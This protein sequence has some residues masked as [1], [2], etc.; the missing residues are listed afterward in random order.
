M[1]MKVIEKSKMSDFIKELLKVYEV[2]APVKDKNIVTFEK[3]SSENQVYLNFQNTKKPLKEVF[4]PQNETLFTYK[5]NGKDMQIVEPP[6]VNGERVVLVVRPCDAKSLVLMDKVFSGQYEDV[7]YLKKRNN[8]TIIGLACNHPLSTCFCTS[9][10]GSP[11]GKEGM[12][13]LLHDLNDKYLLESVTQKGEELIKKFP[14]LKE[15]EQA[16]VEKAKRLSEDAEKSIKCKISVKN[17][18]EELGKKF[19]DPMW[20]QFYQKCLGC[21]ICAFLCPTCTCFDVVDEGTEEGK[22]VRIWDCCQFGCFTLHGSG[23][24]PRPS[25]KERTRQRI[26]HKF[27]YCFSNYGEGFCVGCGRCVRECPVNL[28]VREVIGT[29]NQKC[30]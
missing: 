4:L 17:A 8:T 25:Q 21:G 12:D 26:M 1:K 24:N 27:N 18:C 10:G 28:D 11:S 19:D 30:E 20:D 6:A 3:I 15:A 23:H 2:I 14:D 7:Y 29:I 13:V 16:D 5:G 22:R 9:V